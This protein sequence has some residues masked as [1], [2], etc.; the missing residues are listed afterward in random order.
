MM[1]Q[2]ARLAQMT[3]TART[4]CLFPMSWRP[5]MFLAAQSKQPLSTFFKD[6]DQASRVKMLRDR[7]NNKEYEKIT[8]KWKVPYEK[9]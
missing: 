7:N 6:M 8:N 3:R 1:F 2:A 4:A 5:S 9:K